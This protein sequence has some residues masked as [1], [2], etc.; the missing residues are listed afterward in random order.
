MHS[1][2]NAQRKRGKRIL[3]GFAAEQA[4]KSSESRC[5]NAPLSWGS[6]F[7]SASFFLSFLPSIFSSVRNP[8]CSVT[9]LH[10]H[11]NCNTSGP[12]THTQT[13]SP[14]PVNGKILICKWTTIDHIPGQCQIKITKTS[15]SSV[16]TNLH[17]K[18]TS[19]STTDNVSSPTLLTWYVSED[20]NLKNFK[21][22][23]F[24]SLSLPLCLRLQRKKRRCLIFSHQRVPKWRL[25]WGVW[26]CLD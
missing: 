10:T 5:E 22:E 3:S 18:S 6:F 13:H 2:T 9:H 7:V 16:V 14:F 12:S 26:L 19:R 25:L 23:Q 24:F 17:T 4:V 21:V 20:A 1:H 15:L 8:H 11:I